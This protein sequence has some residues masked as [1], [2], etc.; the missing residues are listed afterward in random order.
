M[1]LE[2]RR[3]QVQQNFTALIQR[4]KFKLLSKP[5]DFQRRGDARDIPA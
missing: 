3:K 1:L 5:N 2:N 4:T